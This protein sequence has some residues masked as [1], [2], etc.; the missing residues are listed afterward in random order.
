MQ[1]FCNALKIDH[2]YSENN[3]GNSG[4]K[5][6]EHCFMDGLY[7]VFRYTVL[8]R[9]ECV[10]FLQCKENN[11]LVCNFD[12]H[13]FVN[14]IYLYFFHHIAVVDYCMHITSV[15]IFNCLLNE[16]IV[17]DIYLSNLGHM[18]YFERASVIIRYSDV[19]I[20]FLTLGWVVK[21]LEWFYPSTETKNIRRSLRWNITP[22]LF[23]KESLKAS[24]GLYS[25]PLQF[26]IGAAVGLFWC[27]PITK[28][29]CSC[30]AS[31]V[32]TI[33]KWWCSSPPIAL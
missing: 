12:L 21:V 23:I 6:N 7:H 22:I 18:W 31:N 33:V 29:V 9:S 24:C 1:Y 30:E 14:G 4:L 3:I 32:M 13:Y 25:Q 5:T 2:R 16:V 11:I 17:Y 8:R 10:L 26:F 28:V 19:L 27:F 15:Y 20:H